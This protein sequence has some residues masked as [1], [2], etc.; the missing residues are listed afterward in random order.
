MPY[1]PGLW[2]HK[3]RHKTFTL[4]VDDFGIKHFNQ[5]DID[6]LI[7]ALKT[8]YTIS[9]DPT[10]SHYCGLQID[11]NY[12]KQY[13]DI[14][15]PGYMAKALQKFQHPTPKKPQYAP[16]AWIPPT[17]G[18]KLQYALPPETLPLL[19]KN[20]TKRVQSITCTFQYY[21][22]G[23]NPPMILEV[24]EL[25]SQQLAPTQETV[26]RCNMLMDYAHTYPN[27]TIRYH[28][29]DMCLHI[30]SDAEYL[31]H[32][33]A[34]SRVA[35]HFY[36][37]D[38]ILYETPTS[39]PTPNGPILIEC[40]TVCNVMSSAEEAETIGIFHHTKV[41]VPILTALTELN[42]PQP[43][44]TIRTDNSTYYGILTSTIRQKRSKDFYMNIYRIK[45]IIK[46][47][48]LFILVYRNK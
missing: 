18:K 31:V 1:N 25:A 33:Q 20:G 32:P 30:E 4:A 14:S 35:G 22:K 24:N 48:N 43:P 23:I 41:A 36:L 47:K 7:N 17:Y 8:H 13:V 38:K 15:I 45:D 16:H 40:R 34:R 10:G 9:E 27:A 21:T 42:R 26:K 44:A 29:S 12:Y 3:T 28:A 6:H 46:R 2:R 37:S 11:W 5:D 19:D 39:N